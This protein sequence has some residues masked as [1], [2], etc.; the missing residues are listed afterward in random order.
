MRLSLEKIPKA[1]RL[2][3]RKLR[4]RLGYPYGGVWRGRGPSRGSRLCLFAH[5]DRHGVVDDYVLNYLER[6]ADQGFVIDLITTSHDLEA[7]SLRRVRKLCRW[8]FLRL[9]KGLDFASWKAAVPDPSTFQDYEVLLLANDS[10]FGPFHDLGP[11]LDQMATQPASLCGLTN[12]YVIA[13]HVQ[14]YFLYIPQPTLL[15]P[16][17]TTLWSDIEP[18]WDKWEIIRRYEVGTS[19]RILQSGGT[20]KAVFSYEAITPALRAMGTRYQYHEDLKIEPLDLMLFAWD[21][22]LEAFGFPFVKTELLKLNRVK[23]TR[24]SQWRDL[25]PQESRHLIPMI[26]RHLQRVAPHGPWLTS[27]LVQ[28]KGMT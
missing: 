6:I 23:S 15:S 1:H 16:T 12:S 24:V 21:V 14:S 19:Q 8:V 7:A 13:H 22:L 3:L 27:G 5:W 20:L 25:V 4:T 11:I 28:S 2:L 18:I 26:E 9:N 17:F 10:V